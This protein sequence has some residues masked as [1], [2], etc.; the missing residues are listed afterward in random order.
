[1]IVLPNTDKDALRG[2]M[3]DIAS[4]MA[5]M[6]AA[7]SSGPRWVA[8]SLALTSA[9]IRRNFG[10]IKVTMDLARFDSR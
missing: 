5:D 6:A 8:P 2:V 7:T 9:Q 1:M 4:E 3:H 10:I